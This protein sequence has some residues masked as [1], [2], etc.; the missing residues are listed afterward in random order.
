MKTM[1]NIKTD[2]EVK[3]EAQKIAKD[4]GLPLSTIINASLKQLIKNR[5]I[6]F[7]A[8]P[9]MTSELEKLLGKVE[10]NIGKKKNI[11]GPFSGI[12]EVSDYLNFL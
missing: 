6:Y 8:L 4:L 1:I 11:A 9:R 7:S 12:D 3:K 5:G 2:K 10:D